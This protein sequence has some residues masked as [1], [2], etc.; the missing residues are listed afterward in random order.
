MTENCVSCALK[1]SVKFATLIGIPCLRIQCVH[2]HSKN[3]T[4]V[5]LSLLSTIIAVFVIFI[6]LILCADFIPH[7]NF[8]R[9]TY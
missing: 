4:I 3:E 5:R 6:V 1:P 9:Q 7:K 2:E 8:V